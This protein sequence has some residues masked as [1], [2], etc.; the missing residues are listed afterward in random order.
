[1]S[2]SNGEA[3]QPAFSPQITYRDMLD[4]LADNKKDGGGFSWRDAVPVVEA[5]RD[6]KHRASYSQSEAAFDFSEMDRPMLVMPIS[7][8]HFGS[9][10]T[11]HQALLKFTDFI[12]STPGL[13]VAVLGDMLQMSINMRGVAEMADNVLTPDLQLRFLESWLEEI[14][15]RV[16][17]STWD[18]HAVMREE[19]NAGSSRYADIFK[20][21]VVYYD[22]IGHASVLVGTQTYQFAASHFFQ[23]RSI[24]NPVHGQIRYGM[25]E[26][27]DADII[28]AGDSHVPGFMQYTRGGKW[29]TA[30][31]CGTAQKQSAY[32]KRFFS[33]KTFADF[34]CLSLHPNRHQVTVYQN[35]ETM[36]EAFGLHK[37]YIPIEAPSI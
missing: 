24:Y 10:G 7:D 32:A 26:N 28:I 16:L 35:V 14:A 20:R 1:M 8:W 3:V 5:M 34:P 11:N 2:H 13:Y 9:F 37:E 29:H 33:L 22:G 12:L 19:K 31:N 4:Y 27:P 17:F 30:I 15:P 18:N 23:G 25:W 21:R 6:L 36:V